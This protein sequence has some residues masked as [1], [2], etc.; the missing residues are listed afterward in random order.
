MED[1]QCIPR[2]TAGVG[3]HKEKA[4]G[5][6]STKAKKNLEFETK[7]NKVY[8]I[9]IIIDNAIYSQLAMVV[10]KC[11]AFITLFCEKAIQKKK[12]L[13][14]FIGSYIPPKIDQYLL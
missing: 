9:K 5:Q 8:E 12:H 2:V 4:S 1:T 6:S 3:H 10:T 7:G 14:A 13:G 11:Q